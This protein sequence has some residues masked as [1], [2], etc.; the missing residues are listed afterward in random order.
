MKAKRI[1]STQ[2]CFRSSKRL[3]VI[4]AIIFTIASQQ[5]EAGLLF[6][7][8][9]EK[10]ELEDASGNNNLGEVK[11]E[12]EQVNGKIGMALKFDGVDDYILLCE[13][14]IGPLIFLHDPFTEKSV[15]AWI[16]A[17]DVDGDHT[18][19]DQGGDQKGYGLRINEGK[20]QLSVSDTSNETT[21]TAN[22]TNKDW[23][24]IAGVFK[25]GALSLYIDGKKVAAGKAPYEEVGSHTDQGALGATFDA[26]AFGR[27]ME[28]VPWNFFQGVIDEFRFFDNALTDQ[29]ISLLYQQTAVEREGKLT[30]TWGELRSVY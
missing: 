22:Y 14:K 29:E 28:E 17:D 4:I 9:F 20:L 12:P 11:G 1:Y 21:V 7:Y 23:H 8:D 10:E 25:K 24:Q 27:N 13:Q 30:T 15:V 19:L 18:I 6:H 3:L 26:D 2:A 16:Q 5:V